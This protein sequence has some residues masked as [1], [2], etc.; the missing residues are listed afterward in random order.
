MYLIKISIKQQKFHFPELENEIIYNYNNFEIQ[1]CYDNFL[2]S[3]S[4]N[5]NDL[6]FTE[7]PTG[8]VI[9]ND[10]NSALDYVSMFFDKTSGRLNVE[11]KILSGRKV[12]YYHTEDEILISS[13]IKL[14]KKAGVQLFENT[15]ILPE[16]FVHRFVTAPNTLYKD[17]FQLKPSE[18]ISVQL[19][20]N[21]IVLLKNKDYAPFSKSS[22]K[23]LVYSN[24]ENYQDKIKNLLEKSLTNLRPVK[25]RV[26]SMLS[27][28]L[29]SSI[30]YK[31]LYHKFNI[32]TSFSTCYP[33]DNK[34]VGEAQYA[35]TAA[36]YFKADH[37]HKEF[38]NNDYVKGVIE[39]IYLAEEPLFH[40]QTVMFNLLFKNMPNNKIVISGQGADGFFGSPSHNSLNNSQK[41]K[42]K[43]LSIP[44]FP[45]LIWKFGDH[46][47]SKELNIAKRYRDT[48]HLPFAN[49][50]HFI[51][52]I[53][54]Q[55]D[56]KWVAKYFNVTEEQINSNRLKIIDNV[57]DKSLYEIM[58]SLDFIGD[59]SAT[60]GIWS[61]IAEAHKNIIYYP[62]NNENLIKYNMSL[63]WDL[64]L[65]KMKG[66]LHYVARQND[67]PEFII[68][69]KK[70]G[71][72]ISP[73]DWI[74]QGV[75]NPLI[76]L[77]AKV[78]D[79]KILK[80]LQKN[81]K[82]FLFWNFLNYAIWKR[83]FIDNESVESL[84]N[85]LELK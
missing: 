48:K 37:Q 59:K 66:L 11:K 74:G 72:F 31:I 69:R 68:N 23:D 52:S 3:V 16:F 2:N 41:L 32:S 80:E 75:M 44:P 57:S 33:F 6:T 25:D 28:G 73:T 19:D 61:K 7:T 30:L 29:D 15:A 27:G 56:K 82:G 12:Y 84:L 18:K 62:F 47:L 34:E 76:P 71:F 14:L 4:E 79:I 53:G 77:A 38:T 22:N 46:S 40:L 83:L 42:Y 51:W 26:T 24:A 9:Q 64:K 63:P 85:E 54:N 35:K 5:D 49:K 65:K 20:G 81:S 45:K 13:H 10:D 36:E 43:L 67:V 39:S 8:N 21:A 17:I 78:V 55:G 70:K 58:T 1:I 60:E 50:D